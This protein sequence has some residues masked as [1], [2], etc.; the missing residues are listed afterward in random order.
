MWKPVVSIPGPKVKKLRSTQLNITFKS[1]DKHRKLF[2]FLLINVKMTKIA[3][4]LTFM[5][6]KHFMLS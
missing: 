6:R 3:G 5:S 4:I 1:L 2:F